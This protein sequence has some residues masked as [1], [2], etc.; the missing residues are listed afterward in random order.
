MI[1]EARL[2][3]VPKSD[4][5][6]VSS[7]GILMYR[8]VGGRLEVLLVHPGGPF[9]RLKDEGAWSIPKGEMNDGED[10]GVA[11]RREFKEETSAAV[12]GLLEPL[13]EIRQRGG[14]ARRRL[15]SKATS[16]SR[17]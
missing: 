12:S 7:A 6:P 1:R 16:T 10:P 15:P 2:P 9:W 14:N 13:G 5:R 4:C 11:A 3:N 17:P 8:R